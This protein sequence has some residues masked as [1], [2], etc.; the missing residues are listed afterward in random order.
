MPSY[1]RI[2]G[3]YV[4]TTLNND[5][6]VIVNTNTLKINGNLDV[7][8]NLT[9]INVDELNVKDPFIVLNASDTGSF[10]A[11]SGVLTHVTSSN[12]AGIRYSEDTDEWQVS[13]NTSASGE[14]GNWIPIA[15]GNTNA[16]GSNTEIQFNDGGSAFGASA[17][18]T[19]DKTTNKLTLQGHQIFGNIATAPDAVANAVAVYHNAEGSGGTGLY[20]KSPTVEDE[21]VS[22]SKAI[23]FAIIF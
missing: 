1:K 15:T 16:A 14:T 18:L 9:Y 10:A 3:D 19:F 12:F 7:V 20:V 8:G 2:D 11:N 6:D 13:S 22:K 23:V 21:L 17:N 5:D 4:I